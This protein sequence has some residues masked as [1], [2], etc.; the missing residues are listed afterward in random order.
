MCMSMNLLNPPDIDLAHRWL[1]M[2]IACLLLSAGVCQAGGLAHTVR[3]AELKLKPSRDAGTIVVLASG[4]TIT[5]GERRGAWFQAFLEDDTQGWI[6]LLAVRYYRAT[7]SG[8]LLDAVSEASRSETT[9]STGVRGL[10]KN[11]LAE[12]KPNHAALQRLLAFEYP[13]SEVKKFAALGGLRAREEA[14]P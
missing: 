14:Y 6:H 9:V 11:M 13:L 7:A 12:S 2:V 8:S 5:I 3:D 4:T 10:D 1:R